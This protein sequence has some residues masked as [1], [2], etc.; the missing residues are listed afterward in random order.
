M[1][2]VNKVI[3]VGNLGKDPEVRQLENTS[4]ARFPLATT[5]NYTTKSGEKMQKTEWHNI[6]VWRGLADVAGKYLQKGKQVYVEGKIRN[7]KWT[8]KEG[9]ER[10]TTEIEAENFTMLGGPSG[11]NAGG[12]DY[13]GSSS[14]AAAPASVPANFETIS[15]SIAADNAEADDLPF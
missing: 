6:V 9:V 5:E 12:G 11:G 10:Y 7:R 4:V 3:L 1:S 13:Q 2:G 8:D 14:S 15:P